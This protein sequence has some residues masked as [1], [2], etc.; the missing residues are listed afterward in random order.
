MHIR[1]SIYMDYRYAK[2]VKWIIDPITPPHNLTWVKRTQQR[3]DLY[4]V[5]FYPESRDRHD[6]IVVSATPVESLRSQYQTA[7]GRGSGYSKQQ[8]LI[9]EQKCINDR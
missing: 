1:L 2:F 3:L 7:M 9:N 4:D 8:V 5:N 6:S